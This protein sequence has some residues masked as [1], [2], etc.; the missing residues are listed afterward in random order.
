M[1]RKTSKSFRKSRHRSGLKEP[2]EFGLYW[3]LMSSPPPWQHQNISKYHILTDKLQ[4]QTKH[5]I[6]ILFI[7]VSDIL[8]QYCFVAFWHC[9]SSD[10]HQESSSRSLGPYQR[11]TNLCSR[12][13]TGESA[14]VLF[15]ELLSS[16]FFLVL[17][18]WTNLTQ[19]CEMSKK[20]QMPF[21]EEHF[22][23]MTELFPHSNISLI[24]L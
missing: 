23:T 13:R 3:T 17:G 1:G 12:D 19:C 15:L 10:H 5:C 16:S 11:F 4:V 20:S 18:F 24:N 7:Q 21:E 14:C 8:F 6:A 2:C 22:C 9:G